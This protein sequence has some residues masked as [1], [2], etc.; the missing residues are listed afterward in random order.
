MI[1]YFDTNVF[2]HIEQRNGVTDW[3]CHILERAVKDGKIAVVLSFLNL[4]ETLFLIN[5]QPQKAKARINLIL[6]LASFRLFIKSQEIVI[7]D[8]IRSYALGTPYVSPFS[9]FEPS[10]EFVI[11]NALDPSEKDEI[12]EVLDEVRQDKE[13][14][15]IMLDDGKKILQPH[16]KKIGA[17]AY[18][19]ERYWESNSGWLAESLA[20][21]AGVL[22]ECKRRGIDGLLKVRSARLA[23]GANLSLMYSHHFENVAPNDGDSRDILHAVLASSAGIFVT[24]DKP[25]ARALR[26]IPMDGFQVT[27]VHALVTALD[28]RGDPDW[29]VLKT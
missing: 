14:F 17:S 8:E 25:F 15:K 5:T 11:R 27:D 20:E 23:V 10:M 21:A 9:D 28:R 3:E 4:E 18:K 12:Q 13:K 1:V 24:H 29:N 2:D 19:F 6:E 7:G 22:D 26:R 16:A